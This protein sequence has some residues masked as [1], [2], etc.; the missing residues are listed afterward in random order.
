MFHTA[1]KW[2]LLFIKVVKPILGLTSDY[3]GFVFHMASLFIIHFLDFFYAFWTEAVSRARFV[4]FESFSSFI[5]SGISIESVT[6]S[7]ISFI[8]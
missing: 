1:N 3:C 6:K 2:I 7:Q 8:F 5:S 4:L